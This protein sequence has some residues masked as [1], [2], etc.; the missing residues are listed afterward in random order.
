VHWA[1]CEYSGCMGATHHSD[2][3]T[4]VHSHNTE[5][6]PVSALIVARPGRMREG[7]RALLRTIPGIKIVEQV[8]RGSAALAMV[9]QERSTLVLLDSSLPSEEM[10]T[11]VKQ[12]KAEWPQ[13]QCIVVADTIR[14]QGMAHAS[15]A[16]GVLLKGFAAETL[17][18]TIDEVLMRVG[19]LNDNK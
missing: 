18:T 4:Q 19:K 11:A 13:T 7:L 3:S 14:Q 16:D 17:F 10:W 1:D 8:D 12:I 15:G 9:T 6:N 2:D 5:V